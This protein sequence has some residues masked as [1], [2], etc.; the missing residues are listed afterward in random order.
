MEPMLRLR[1]EVV[2]TG[3]T[4]V[5]ALETLNSRCK[6]NLGKSFSLPNSSLPLSLSLL[7]LFV[8]IFLHSGPH[9]I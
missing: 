3:V 8:Y 7:V 6:C 4:P 1:Q 2:R 9:S 5:Q